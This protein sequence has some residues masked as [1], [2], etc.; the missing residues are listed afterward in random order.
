MNNQDRFVN[1]KWGM[2]RVFG[3]PHKTFLNKRN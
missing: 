2:S 1:W 3:T